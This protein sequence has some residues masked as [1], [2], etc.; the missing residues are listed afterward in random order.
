MKSKQKYPEKVRH[1]CISLLSISPRAYRLIRKTFHNHLPTE[2]TIQSWFSKSDIRGDPG[3]QNDTLNR[4]GKIAKDF[5][6]KHKRKLLAS[7]VFDE[8]YIRQQ[9]YWSQNE[10]EYTGFKNYGEISGKTVEKNIAKQAI[11]FI[12]NGIDVNFEFPFAYN[13]I[14]ELDKNERRDLLRDVITAITK[15]GIRITNVT[16]DGHVS[17][18]PALEML[19]A[20]LK[21][22]VTAKKQ[23]IKPFIINPVSN[24]KIF[25]LLDPCHMLKLVRNRLASCGKFID[26][27]DNTIEWRYIVSLHEYSVK[28]GLHTHKLTKKHIDWERHSMNVRIACETLSDSVANSIQYLMDKNVPDFQGAQPTIDFV[29]RINKLFDCF[30]SRHSCDQ[31]IFKRKLSKENNRII[32]DFFKDTI[33]FF[34]SLKVE[35]VYYKK[36]QMAKTDDGDDAENTKNNGKEKKKKKAKRVI[37]RIEIHPILHT[38]HKTA[39]RGFIIDMISLKEMFNIYIEEEAIL[40]SMPTYNLLQDVLEMLFAR[41]R[42]CGGYNNN[43]NVNQF[44]GVCFFVYFKT[45]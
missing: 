40:K 5:E 45:K 21:W 28:Y 30:N 15:C 33:K 34:T 36:D 24:E 3:I 37:G 7:L 4:L 31:N 13:F 1:F 17:N 26:P 43:P 8:M 22:N 10:M 27:D 29:R 6:T 14:N 38:N 20:H 11:V 39:F 16:F 41:I 25:V 32:F 12:L 42:A 19:G 18:V 2:G 44:K 9:V 35:V 23:N